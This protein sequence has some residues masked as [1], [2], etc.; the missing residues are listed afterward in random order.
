MDKAQ[1]Q[2]VDTYFRKRKLATEV[3]SGMHFYPYE[4]NY[5]ISSGQKN[6]N[7]FPRKTV[8]SILMGHPQWFDNVIK[9]DTF[10]DNEIGFIL[11]SQP[12]LFDRFNPARI[13]ALDDGNIG[14]ILQKQPQLADRF[15]LADMSHWDAA[16]VVAEQPQLLSK[17]NVD[18]F[19]GYDIN[20]ILEKQP[21]LVD[22]FDLNKLQPLEFI[23]ILHAQPQLKDKFHPYMYK[24]NG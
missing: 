7:D 16:K 1:K 9:P 10:K 4:L 18:G 8:V 5:Q 15:D 3:G 20:T 6:I 17:F 12:Q 14:L 23:Q 22:S 11:S 21:Q 13:R 2:L 24:K 19:N